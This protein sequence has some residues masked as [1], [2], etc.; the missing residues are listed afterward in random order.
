MDSVRPEAAF[1]GEQLEA[2]RAILDG[3]LARLRRVVRGLDLDEP[4][5]A[6]VTLLWFAMR[7]ERLQAVE[8]LVFLGAQP[9]ARRVHG[10][11]SALDYA[12]AIGDPRVLAA[13]L[14]GG[15]SVSHTRHGASL[16]HRAAE[17]DGATMGHLRFLLERGADLEARDAFGRTPLLAALDANH[18]ERATY[19]LEQGASLD[20]STTSG[21]TPAWLLE[22]KLMEHE[23]S[24][25]VPVL[26]ALKELMIARGATFPPEDPG[27]VCARLDLEKL[28]AEQRMVEP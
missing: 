24:N 21:E 16:L 11:G 17:V 12:F 25:L 8:A 10:A 2:A 28:E 26:E 7:E 6:G 22:I 9:D 13:M 19:L 23:N 5:R 3:N 1:E 4:S 20:V 14:N 27:E 15:L 18:F